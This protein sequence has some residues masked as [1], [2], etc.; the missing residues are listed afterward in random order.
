MPDGGNPFSIIS[1]TNLPLCLAGVENTD[2]LS[3]GRE[4]RSNGVA[5]LMEMG[6]GKT[7]TSVGT[8]MLANVKLLLH[9]DFSRLFFL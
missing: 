2:L 6:T 3:G 9:D 8:A 1:E 4:Y 5:L 7:I